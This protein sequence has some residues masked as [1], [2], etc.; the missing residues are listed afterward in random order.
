MKS[1]KWTL[2][3]HEKNREFV[4][5]AIS[6]VFS[7]SKMLQIHIKK[8]NE[9]PQN[10]QCALRDK[11]YA[12]NSG[13]SEPGGGG[14]GPPSFWQISEQYLNQGGGGGACPPDFQ[15]FLRL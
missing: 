7:L 9:K 14:T 10:W 5:I 13:L 11:W 6:Q 8:V 1:S 3:F 12:L 2:Q 4:C 15:T